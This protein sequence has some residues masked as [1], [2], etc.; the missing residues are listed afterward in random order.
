MGKYEK[1][2]QELR[3]QYTDEEIADAMLI[4]ADL[5][6]EEREA[7]DAAIKAFRFELLRNRTEEQRIL[8]D[9]M[10]FRFQL[11]RYIKED[12]YTVEKSFGQQLEEYA[13]ILKKTKKQLSEDVAVHYTR[14][15]RIIN[16]KE[17]PNTELVYR[18]EEHSG[19]LVPAL[20]WWRLI[21]KKEEYQI[22]MDVA[23]KREEAAKVK[24]AVRV[25][26]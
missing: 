21:V 7:A 11:E 12:S 8:S 20:V 1:I 24:N 16:N 10:R 22:R 26:G 13:R 4:P 15:S 17:K 9:L 3:K 18:L 6:T 2:Y 23:T 14:L 25:G 19:S 5:T